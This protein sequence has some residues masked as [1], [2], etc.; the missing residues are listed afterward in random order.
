[1]TG[2]DLDFAKARAR[3]GMPGAANLVHALETV[4][5]LRKVV[6]D[7]S[8]EMTALRNERDAALEQL[9]A[10]SRSQRRDES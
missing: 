1:M 7:Y 10:L 5:T 2:T 3:A 9:A 8:N 6:E 4:Q